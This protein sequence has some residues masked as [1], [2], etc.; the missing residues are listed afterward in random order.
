MAGA[1]SHLGERGAAWGV[2]LTAG[3]YRILGRTACR[4]MLAPVVA[5]FY[6]TDAQRRRASLSYLERAWRAGYLPR[7]PGYGDGFRHFLTF[8]Y[9]SLDKVAA[10]NGDIRAS[11]VDGVHDG[12]FDEAKLNKRGAV[13]ITAHVGSPEV[14]RAI[15]TVNRRFRVNVLVHTLHA[16]RFNRVL[17]RL[18]PES[19]VH[20]IQ[21][22]DIDVSVAMRLSEAVGRGEW[23]VI[24]GDRLAVAGGDATAAEVEFLGGAAKFPVGPYVLAAALGCPAYTLFCTRQGK[25][26]SVVFD[27]F[28][29]PVTL[30]RRDRAAATQAYAA[31]FAKRL[32]KIVALDPFQWFNFY[33]YWLQD[34]APLGGDTQDFRL[35]S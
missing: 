18:S 28:A 32:E 5:Y 23:V 22:S 8:A 6:A 16:E 11:D 19:P 1:W 7:K 14:I 33:D 17:K 12:L 3:V 30:P 13:V 15:A 10:W 4:V 29:D 9:A 26:F 21:V 2:W 27:L 35:E 31:V 24:M 25:R 20:L 34:S